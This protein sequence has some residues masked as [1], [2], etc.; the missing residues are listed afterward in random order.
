MHS[1]PADIRPLRTPTYVA[2]NKTAP[3]LSFTAVK[4]HRKLGYA[5]LNASL[6]NLEGNHE[7]RPTSQG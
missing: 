1:K 5:T 7:D 3:A 4:P 6:D 2:A